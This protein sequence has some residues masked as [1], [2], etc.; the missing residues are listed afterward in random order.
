MK[1]PVIILAVWTIVLVALTALAMATAKPFRAALQEPCPALLN[2]LVPPLERALSAWH[3]IFHQEIVHWRD[4]ASGEKL[5]IFYE[6]KRGA[7]S[8]VSMKSSARYLIS[9]LD[10]G[11]AYPVLRIDYANFGKVWLSIAVVLIAFFMLWR[12]WF[13]TE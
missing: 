5:S 8:C 12:R 7:R 6:G 13:H 4:A 11:E 9:R 10:R 1:T 2:Q 3:P